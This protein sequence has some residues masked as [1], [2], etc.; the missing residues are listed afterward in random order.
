MNSNNNMVQF[1]SLIDKPRTRVRVNNKTQRFTGRHQIITFHQLQQ[2]VYLYK[3][4]RL[5]QEL[6][7]RRTSKPIKGIARIQSLRGPVEELK[8]QFWVVN[9]IKHMVGNL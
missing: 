6:Q 5:G 9:S 4:S 8:T 2:I 3:D 7:K 1:K